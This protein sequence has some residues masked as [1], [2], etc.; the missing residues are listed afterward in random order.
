MVGKVHLKEI[1][2]KLTISLTFFTAWDQALSSLSCLFTLSWSLT[3]VAYKFNLKYKNKKAQDSHEDIPVRWQLLTFFPCIIV[4]W[5]HVAL[6]SSLFLYSGWLGAVVMAC[7][8][9]YFCAGPATL[10]RILCW[11]VSNRPMNLLT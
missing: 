3:K 9:F 6:P 11:N 10:K 1:L 4:M 5:V 8:F 2:N 7:F